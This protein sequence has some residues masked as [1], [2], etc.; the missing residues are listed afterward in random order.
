[1][2]GTDWGTLVDSH[3]HFDVAPFEAYA[4]LAAMGVSHVVTH[5]CLFGASGKA[6]CLDQYARLLERYRPAAAGHLID[7]R[8]CLGIHPLGI[9]PDWEALIEELPPLLKREGV[10]GIGEVGLHTGSKL[11]AA[12]LLAQ[13][14]LAADLGLPVSIHLPP[15]ERAGIVG[16]ALDLIH[17]SGL[18]PELACLEHAALDM[19]AEV[20]SAGCWLGLS[21][22]R[23]RLDAAQLA[24]SP[25]VFGRGMLSSDYVNFLPRDWDAVPRCV[26]ELRRKGADEGFIRAV[27]SENARAFY[28]L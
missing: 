20:A 18:S 16:R 23:G 17:E 2:S 11:E 15:G 9:P 12:V 13:L 6:S 28:R 19:A 25:D 27:A 8:V 5:A 4:T 7:L 21:L 1:M 22:G 10:V 26:V 3:T 14:R 24:A